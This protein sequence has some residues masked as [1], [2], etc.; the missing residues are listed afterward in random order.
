MK[1]SDRVIAKFSTDF[2][3]EV[4]TVVDIDTESF[5]PVLHVSFKGSAL[6][7][8]FTREQLEYADA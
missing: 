3:G 6:A 1:I 2:P 5:H 7:Y 4:G 8:G